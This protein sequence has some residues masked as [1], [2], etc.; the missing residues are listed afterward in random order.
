MAWLLRLS[1]NARLSWIDTP[2]L[3]LAGF[4]TMQHQKQGVHWFDKGRGKHTIPLEAPFI[5]VSHLDDSCH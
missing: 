1:H 2:H 4:I 5:K 3:W